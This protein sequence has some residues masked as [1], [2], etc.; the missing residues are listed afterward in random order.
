MSRGDFHREGN[1]VNVGTEFKSLRT[2]LK[3]NTLRRL[4]HSFVNRTD[5]SNIRHGSCYCDLFTKIWD[6]DG[7]QV[8]IKH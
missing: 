3:V 7:R 5:R 4:D 2:H 8:D 6:C 1:L